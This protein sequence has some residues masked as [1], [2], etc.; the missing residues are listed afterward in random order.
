MLCLFTS[1]PSLNSE[2]SLIFF[3]AIAI[4]LFFLECLRFLGCTSD[5]ESTCQ[6]RRRRRHGFHPWVRKIPWRRAWHPIPVFLPGESHGQ[7]SLAGCSPW[8]RKDNHPFLELEQDST[9]LT[10][11]G[12]A[13]LC[14]CGQGH[15]LQADPCSL[16]VTLSSDPLKS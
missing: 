3:E 8:G 7:R 14:L 9:P 11:L 1:L 12:P 10:S 16:A 13:G 5:K 15:P 6:Y 2:Q 4:V